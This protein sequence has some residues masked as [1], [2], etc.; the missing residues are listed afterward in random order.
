MLAWLSGHL[1]ELK[2]QGTKGTERH[3][4]ALRS[5]PPSSISLSPSLKRNRGRLLKASCLTPSRAFLHMTF[6][7]ET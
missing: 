1:L 5:N 7:K 2:V 3:R 4:A 6:A